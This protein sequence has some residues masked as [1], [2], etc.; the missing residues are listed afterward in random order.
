[1]AKHFALDNGLR[2][3]KIIPVDQA[4][5]AS[6]PRSP[7]HLTIETVALAKQHN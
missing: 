2:R 4:K 5:L 1:M 3:F 7:N 6:L